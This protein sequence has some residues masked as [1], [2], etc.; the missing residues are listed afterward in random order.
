LVVGKAR[1]K[2]DYEKG[3]TMDTENAIFSSTPSNA[4]AFL[5][6]GISVLVQRYPFKL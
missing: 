6:I 4:S 5:F 3:E 1:N 2:T